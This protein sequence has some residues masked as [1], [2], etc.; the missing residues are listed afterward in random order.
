M[1][2]VHRYFTSLPPPVGKR[3]VFF[4]WLLFLVSLYLPALRMYFG[5]GTGEPGLV[6]GWGCAYLLLKFLPTMHFGYFDNFASF[7]SVMA[8]ALALYGCGVGNLAALFAPLFF[9]QSISAKILRW[10]TTFFALVTFCALYQYIEGFPG[11]CAGYFVWVASFGML[12]VGSLIL[13]SQ[14]ASKSGPGQEAGDY[15][16]RTPEEMAAAR[17]LKEYLRLPG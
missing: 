9:R 3:L 16:P 5:C 11:Y 4:G 15:H 17:E 12:T 10:R 2:S 8:S 1:K 6:Y 7:L 14:L 13:G